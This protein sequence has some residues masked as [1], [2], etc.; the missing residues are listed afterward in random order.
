M[1]KLIKFIAFC[2]KLLTKKQLKI[3]GNFRN[4]FYL[5]LWTTHKKVL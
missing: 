3:L 4:N 5:L 2:F 1:L